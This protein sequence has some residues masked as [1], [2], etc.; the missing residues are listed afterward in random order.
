MH[1]AC[2]QE[3]FE[4]KKKSFDE[5]TKVCFGC[6]QT[7]WESL[8]HL[9]AK[10]GSIHLKRELVCSAYTGLWYAAELANLLNQN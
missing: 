7:T 1:E 10:C 5:M 8:Q 2:Y 3:Y 9:S 6:K 4:G